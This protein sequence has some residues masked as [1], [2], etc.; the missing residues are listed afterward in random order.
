MA[1][2]PA[3]LLAMMERGEVFLAMIKVIFAM[4]CVGGYVKSQLML[5]VILKKA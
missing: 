2:S 1:A 4:L 3:R 5:G